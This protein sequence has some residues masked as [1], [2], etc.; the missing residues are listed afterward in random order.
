MKKNEIRIA[1]METNLFNEVSALAKANKR[2]IGKQ[3]EFMLESAAEKYREKFTG[4]AL[5]LPL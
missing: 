4:F 5:A 1:N 3:A 2:T